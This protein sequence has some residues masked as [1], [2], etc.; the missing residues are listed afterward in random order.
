MSR[1]STS[2][3][4]GVSGNPRGRPKADFDLR[5]FARGYG[6]PV[7]IG[8]AGMAGL[9]PDTPASANE[10]VRLGAM[11]ELLDRGFG[12]PIQPL[13]GEPA[14]PLIV[15]FRWADQVPAVTTTTAVI[16]AVAEQAEDGAEPAFEVVWKGAA[17]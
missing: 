9:L 2:F 1:T 6:R 16:E 10:A 14:A 5:E 4:P 7:I 12:R 15:D 17:D 13:V 3:K 11:R 8:L